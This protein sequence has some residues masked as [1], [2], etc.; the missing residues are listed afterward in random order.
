MLNPV[1]VKV[2]PEEG[3]PEFEFAKLLNKFIDGVSLFGVREL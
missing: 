3:N 1:G 2:N